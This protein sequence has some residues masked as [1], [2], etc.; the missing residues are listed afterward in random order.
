MIIRTIVPSVGLH[1]E[2]ADPYPE[3]NHDRTRS[4]AYSH[5]E[6][7][8]KSNVLG[9]VEVGDIIRYRQSWRD[10]EDRIRRIQCCQRHVENIRGTLFVVNV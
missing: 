7:D 2:K 5:G 10:F 3:K 1:D 9:V 6:L 8:Q 4:K